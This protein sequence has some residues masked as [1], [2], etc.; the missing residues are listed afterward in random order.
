MKIYLVGGAVRDQLLKLPVKER[1]YVVVGATR[2]QMLQLGFKQVGKDFPVFLHPLTN[3]EYALARTERK[4]GRGYLGFECF[5]EPTVSL[6]DDLKRRDLTMNAIALDETNGQ[7]IDPYGGQQDLKNKIIR[8]VSDAFIED[9]LRILRVARFAAKFPDF[10][11]ASQTI[12]LMKQM[13]QEIDALVPERVWQEWQK[14]F[15]TRS[16][17]RFIQVLKQIGALEKLF[18][19]IAPFNQ[20]IYQNLK[21][22]TSNFTSEEVFGAIF[23]AIPLTNAE[24]FL[25][26]YRI[27]KQQKSLVKALASLQTLSAQSSLE[28]VVTMLENLNCFRHNPH[29]LTSLNILARIHPQNKN[30]LQHVYQC[31]QI[32]NNVKIT[33]SELAR[34]API[35][36][37]RYLHQKRLTAIQQTFR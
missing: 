32:A 33:E 19:E 15:V 31:Y 37:K 21:K 14:S 6:E 4:N 29:L 36:I 7:L 30:F 27:S 8:H 1:D 18:P 23:A 20:R 17:I 35:Q 34:L 28:N 24:K 22:L 26:R 5:A 2:E 13:V 25:N 9:P 3:A 10:K 12:C 11:I 16:P